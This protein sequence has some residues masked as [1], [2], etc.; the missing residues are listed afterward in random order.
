MHFLAKEIRLDYSIRSI[1]EKQ[2][3][4]L[5]LLF[6]FL[7]FDYSISKYKFFFL[8]CTNSFGQISANLDGWMDGW[9]DQWTNGWMDRQ[10]VGRTFRSVS[11][12][13][14]ICNLRHGGGLLKIEGMLA[15]FCG[16]EISEGRNCQT[17]EICMG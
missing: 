2:F 11:A 6:Y 15:K 8:C 9:M 1:I 10:T 5:N 17:I 13:S 4:I 3:D 16:Q 14:L 12:L 7:L